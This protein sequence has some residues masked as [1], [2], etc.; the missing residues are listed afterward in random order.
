[1]VHRAEQTPILLPLDLSVLVHLGGI[2]G[3]D[4]P[5]LVRHGGGLRDDIARDVGRLA[6][7]RS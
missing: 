3:D 2:E 6:L 7:N 4:I 5:S 1:M